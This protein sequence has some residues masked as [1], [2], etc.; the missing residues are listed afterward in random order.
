MTID[1]WGI[2]L[3][4]V[5]VA[6]L[7]WLLSRVFWRPVAAAITTRQDAAKLMT[8]TATATQTKAE[9]ALAQATQAHAGI[10]EERTAALE[11]ARAEAQTAS[12]AVLAEAQTKA[13]ALMVQARI[14]ISSDA[15]AGDKANA[16]KASDLSLKIAARLLERLNSAAVQS[17]F[18]SH[19]V[20]AIEKL[21]A[22][23]RIALGAKPN[24]VEVVT[25]FE[26]GTDAERRQIEKAVRAALGGTAD[27]RFVVDPDLI[28]GLELRSPHFILRNSWQADLI[29]I[30]KALE[31]EAE[32][33]KAVKN[34]A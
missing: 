6:V 3:Q 32:K 12:K 11:A 30:Q 13:D 15:K 28:G 4:A 29:Q 23:D 20:E 33:Q 26:P 10:A 2:G 31:Q 9:A 22:D 21:P 27:L 14:K 5:N 1:F 19:L 24:G 18:L 17:A 34:A 16:A 8:D 7:V 25:A